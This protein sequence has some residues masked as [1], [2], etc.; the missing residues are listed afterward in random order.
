MQQFLK[1]VPQQRKN[2]EL[3]ENNIKARPEVCTYNFTS[4]PHSSAYFF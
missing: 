2:L 1:S 4:E 3:Y